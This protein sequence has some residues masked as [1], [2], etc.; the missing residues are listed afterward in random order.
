MWRGEKEQLLPLDILVVEPRGEQGYAIV[1][2]Y[3]YETV[4]FSR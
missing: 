1:A 2:H 3:A 4:V